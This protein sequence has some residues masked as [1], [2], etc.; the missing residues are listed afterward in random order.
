MSTISRVVVC[1]AA[2]L[3]TGYVPA[4]RASEMSG[5]G[6]GSSNAGRAEAKHELLW[7]ARLATPD[8]YSI[9]LDAVDLPPGDGETQAAL[10][11]VVESRTTGPRVELRCVSTG[12]LLWRRLPGGAAGGSAFAG[13]ARGPECVVAAGSALMFVDGEGSAIASVPLPRVLRSVAV[14][15][16]RAC[17]CAGR[18]EAGFADSLVLFERGSGSGAT[19]APSRRSPRA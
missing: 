2:L 7:S 18:P 9:A 17:V 19:R 11:V 4:V 14:A 13:V 8:I 3:V 12:E 10:L 15:G 5:E 16:S 6:L 1:A